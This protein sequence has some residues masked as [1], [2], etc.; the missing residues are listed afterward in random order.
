MTFELCPRLLVARCVKSLNGPGRAC[1][2]RS[3]CT[4]SLDSCAKFA[5]LLYLVRTYPEL[6]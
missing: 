5:G 4:G 6:I 1:N 2:S 3:R